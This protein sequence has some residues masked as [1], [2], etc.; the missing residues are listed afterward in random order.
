MWLERL[1]VLAWS[2]HAASWA[3]AGTRRRWCSTAPGPRVH[4][5]AAEYAAPFVCI[6]HQRLAA[7]PDM[8]RTSAAMAPSAGEVSGGSHGGKQRCGSTAWQWLRGGR[9]A[10]RWRGCWHPPRPATPSPIH[11]HP[12]IQT[13]GGTTQQRRNSRLGLVRCA[14]RRDQSSRGTTVLHARALHRATTPQEKTR[15]RRCRCP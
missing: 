6:G 7:G 1:S 8:A 12:P 15:A 13:S 5:V 3:S 11:R 14:S 10:S 4:L 9:L 2:Y